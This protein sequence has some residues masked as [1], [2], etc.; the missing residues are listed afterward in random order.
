MAI[1]SLL[2]QFKDMKSLLNTIIR[3][4][5]WHDPLIG[6]KLFLGQVNLSIGSFTPPNW[7]HTGW[8]WLCSRPTAPTQNNP[9]DIGSL[10]IKVHY[11]QDVIYPLRIYDNLSHMLVESTTSP[12]SQSAKFDYKGSEIFAYSTCL[13][14]LSS[15]WEKS[16]VI[17]RQ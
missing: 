12:V 5:V 13:I 1:I 11:S 16:T 4:S 14:L 10:R 2:M 3:V 9:P 7:S 6:E 8:Y 15:F 17:G